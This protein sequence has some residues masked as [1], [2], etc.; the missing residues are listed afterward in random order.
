MFTLTGHLIVLVVFT[1]IACFSAFR[2]TIELSVYHIGYFTA[3]LT[4][5]IRYYGVLCYIIY[6]YSGIIM[7]GT[8][9]M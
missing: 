3:N 8:V 1:V 9:Y 7:H 4:Y 2:P 6:I 5:H